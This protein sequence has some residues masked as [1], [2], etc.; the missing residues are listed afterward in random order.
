MKNARPFFTNADQYA[1]KATKTAEP[2]PPIEALMDGYN[3]ELR[4]SFF[5]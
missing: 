5:Y 4:T 1:D 3:I 2:T